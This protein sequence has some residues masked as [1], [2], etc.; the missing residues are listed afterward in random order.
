ML[1]ESHNIKMNFRSLE[2]TL[3]K[4][5]LWRRINKTDESEVASFIQQLQTSGRQHGYRWMHQKC[6]M[7]GIITDRETVRLLLCLMDGEGVA[8][9]ASSRGPNYIWHIDGYDKG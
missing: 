1:E 7:A 8:L 3:C 2:R 9:R 5:H 6:W 4:N